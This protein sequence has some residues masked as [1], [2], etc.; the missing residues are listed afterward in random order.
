MYYWNHNGMGGWVWLVASLSAIL[1]WALIVLLIVLLVRTMRHGPVTRH[2]GVS[3]PSPEQ[4]LAERFARGEIDE[5]EYRR[6]LE[7][8]REAR[9]DSAKRGRAP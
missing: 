8:L 4:V 3:M 7:V 5:E 9:P 1:F 6:R 2:D